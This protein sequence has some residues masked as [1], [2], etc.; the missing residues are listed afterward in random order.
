VLFIR[1]QALRISPGLKD[2]NNSL[3][4]AYARRAGEE[5]ARQNYAAAIAEG[6]R[7]LK[8]DPFHLEAMGARGVARAASGD[9][10]GAI[11]DLQTVLARVEPQWPNRAACQEAL[12]FAL[13][14]R[15]R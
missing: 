8:F 5:L 4:E 10:D 7:A 14:V 2:A 15:R 1:N 9:P 13:R 3:G 11:A 12:E 6:T